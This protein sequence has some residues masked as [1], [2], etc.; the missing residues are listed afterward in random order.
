MCDN[1][2]WEEILE[3]CEKILEVTENPFVESLAI[4]IE[5]KEHVTPKQQEKIQDI[6]FGLERDGRV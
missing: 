2:D 4:R 3:L 1:C 6:Y 5:E